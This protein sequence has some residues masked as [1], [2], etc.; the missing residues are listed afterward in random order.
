MEK[1]IQDSCLL[2]KS[3]TSAFQRHSTTELT[4]SPF[5]IS[6]GYPVLTSWTAGTKPHSLQGWNME[7]LFSQCWS[8]GLKC[9]VQQRYPSLLV[10]AEIP[11]MTPLAPT[12][13]LSLWLWQWQ[14]P[15]GF[16]LQLFIYMCSGGR[17]CML[18]CMCG[19]QRTILWSWLFA[20][21]F[22]WVLGIKQASGLTR[23]MPFCWAILLAP[24]ASY[25]YMT[26]FSGSL[27]P[28]F[29][30]LRHQTSK[31]TLNSRSLANCKDSIRSYL[32]LG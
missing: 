32:R 17:D 29:L 18:Q 24:V 11:S 22:R 15:A 31:F 30:L 27:D 8:L 3:D 13:L 12:I 9:R 23:Q 10:P 14:Y 25:L 5:S 1:S 6:P 16:F 7:N 19:R 21:T 20:S 26:S 28:K 4:P 2:A